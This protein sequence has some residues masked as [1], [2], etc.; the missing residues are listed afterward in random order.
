MH[1]LQ[2]LRLNLPWLTVGSARRARYFALA[3]GETLF[4]L[5]RPVIELDLVEAAGREREKSH[6][7]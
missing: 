1:V 7:A 2:L 3:H 4:M 5:L 6:Y